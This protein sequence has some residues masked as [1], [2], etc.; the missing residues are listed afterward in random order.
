MWLCGAGESLSL[1]R[2]LNSKL[3]T[4]S[5]PPYPTPPHPP[6]PITTRHSYMAHTHTHTHTTEV[7]LSLQ[8]QQLNKAK[9]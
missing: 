1:D 3:V 9:S 2:A 8:G 6:A 5:T 4:P 7:I